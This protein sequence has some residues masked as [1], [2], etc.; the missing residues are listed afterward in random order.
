MQLLRGWGCGSATTGGQ[1]I[2]LQSIN[3]KRHPVCRMQWYW[4]FGEVQGPNEWEK[5]VSKNRETF[6]L[7]FDQSESWAKHH[8]IHY[9]QYSSTTV[10]TTKGT[11]KPVQQGEWVVSFRMYFI[12]LDLFPPVDHVH[13]LPDSDVRRNWKAQL[14]ISQ[15]LTENQLSYDC[16]TVQLLH[17][18]NSSSLDEV[19]ATSWPIL[20]V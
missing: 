16:T 1:E 19:S 20:S 2:L 18:C 13:L 17:D 9:K 12:N 7:N 3:T 4:M 15:P 6:C 10:P 8:L 14:C 11:K 5:S